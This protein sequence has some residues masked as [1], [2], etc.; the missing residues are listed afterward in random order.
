MA[1]NSSRRF[2]P[3][4]SISEGHDQVGKVTKET[5][6]KPV[7]RCL[8]ERLLPDYPRVSC[9]A[10]ALPPDLLTRCGSP[11]HARTVTAPVRGRSRAAAGVNQRLHPAGLPAPCWEGQG[12]AFQVPLG[13]RGH[14]AAPP[15]HPPSPRSPGPGLGLLSRTRVGSF[16]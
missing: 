10:A 7:R 6:E 16:P 13:G 14:G 4:S 5:A 3:R 9:G 15:E 8:P 1:R 11:R 12:R 2:K